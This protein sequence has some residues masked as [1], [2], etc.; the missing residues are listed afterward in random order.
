MYTGTLE[1][2]LSYDN[3]EMC[4][5]VHVLLVVML[6]LYEHCKPQIP[7]IKGRVYY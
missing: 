5:E 3:V 1:F 4:A 7:E 6:Y 2:K